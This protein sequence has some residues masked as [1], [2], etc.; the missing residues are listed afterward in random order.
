M[1]APL[2]LPP[3]VSAAFEVSLRHGYASFCR[4]ETG[5][6]LAALAATRS[7]TLAEFGTGTGVG[8]AW[9]RSGIRPGARILSAELD[10]TLADAATKLFETDDQVE[11][12]AADW[13][14]LSGRSPFSLLFLDAREPEHSGADTV[15]D[16]M[17]EGGIVVIDDLVPCESW[18]PLY[19][20]R[21]DSVREAWLTDDR[22]TAVEVMVA[23]DTAVLLATKR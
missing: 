13:S 19:A 18:P 12:V 17:E 22:F 8:T 21:V 11:V 2:E 16:L 20:G 5:R 10:P 4:N 3:V 14:T 23:S 15:I 9:L 1:S 7:G 6:L